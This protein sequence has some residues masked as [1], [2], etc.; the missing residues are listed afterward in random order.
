[1]LPDRVS[2]IPKKEKWEGR[3]ALA[4]IRAYYETKL[5]KTVCGMG[6]RVHKLT[7]TMEFRN[8]LK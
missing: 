6:T 4:D 5:T 7:K 3:L 8:R 1:M 2:E